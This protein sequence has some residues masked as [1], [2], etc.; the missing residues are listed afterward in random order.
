MSFHPIGTMKL[1][2]FVS[3]CSALL[4]GASASLFLGSPRAIAAEKIVLKYG[5]FAQS[6]QV[7]D[8]E[9][10]VK[11]GNTTP[12]LATII[13]LSKQDPQ[14]LRGLMSLEL[15]VNVVTLDRILNSKDGEAALMAIGKT[16]RTRSR[17]E[18]DKALR[19]AVILAASD[20]KLS[21]LE[22]LQKYPTSEI[23]VEIGSIGSTVDQLKGF[24]GNLQ[25]LLKSSTSSTTT[26]TPTARPQTTVQP[27][28][29]VQPA[30][31]V[32]PRRLTAPPATTP[33]PVPVAPARPVRGLW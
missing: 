20:N 3:L 33:A 9:N 28:R 16:V 5:P 12:T 32:T 4:L 23:D 10:F 6:V 31:P 8:L 22:V 15:G 14:T 24:A 7:S 21:L 1:S 13:R 18:S 2:T 27:P 29:P 11:T 26:T 30:A 25:N 19:A 17:A